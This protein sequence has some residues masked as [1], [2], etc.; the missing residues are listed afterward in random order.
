MDQQRASNHYFNSH[1]SRSMYKN[2]S[3]M[4]QIQDIAPKLNGKKILT[5]STA[6]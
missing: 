6:N 1:L 2:L 5:M 4:N 3:T